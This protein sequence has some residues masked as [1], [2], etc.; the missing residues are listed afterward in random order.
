[1]IDENESD[2]ILSIETLA[3]VKRSGSGQWQQWDYHV[4]PLKW[5]NQ[6]VLLWWEICNHVNTWVRSPQLKSRW[7]HRLIVCILGKFLRPQFL[8]LYTE[9]MN[10]PVLGVS[11]IQEHPAWGQLDQVSVRVL[12]HSFQCWM[13]AD[14][15][16]ITHSPNPP[17]PKYTQ[18]SYCICFSICKTKYT[19]V[20][21]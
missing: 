13:K 15:F 10:P 3:V 17:S 19:M 18:A 11:G 4:A 20:Y 21:W 5:L 14:A 2:K 12:S 6:N 16:D 9:G 8:L 1:M 7:P